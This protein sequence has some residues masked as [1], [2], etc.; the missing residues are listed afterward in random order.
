MA[1]ILFQ[2]HG[3]LRLTTAGGTVIYIDPYVGDGYDA[4]ADLVLVS[5][6]HHDHNRVEL[7]TL[8][9]DGKI[10]RAGDFLRDGVYREVV[11]KDVKIKGTEAYNKNHPR[12]A[13]V[14]FLV[15]ADGKTIYFAGDTSRTE[16][17]ET[18]L[19]KLPIDYAF[20]PTDGV[21]NMDP[22]EASVCAGLIGAAHTI[23]IHMAP[24]K[25]FDQAAAEQFEAKGRIILK[26]GETIRW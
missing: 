13:C 15:Q 24:G 9:E 14:G 21:Y 10:L 5:H 3:S 26:P 22:K 11:E 25:L 2:G 19:A 4:L 1:E 18:E 17:M 16:A 23:P 6:E 20:L 12:N 8:K 7:V